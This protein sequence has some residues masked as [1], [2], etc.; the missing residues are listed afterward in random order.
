MRAFIFPIWPE[1][2][3]SKVDVGQSLFIFDRAMCRRIWDS[4]RNHSCWKLFKVHHILRQSTC[5]VWEYITN[6][7]QFFVQV[8]WLGLSRHIFGFI[9]H[10]GVVFD[11]NSLE[12][13]NH[14]LRDQK[15]TWYEIHHGQKPS[16]KENS[17]LFHLIFYTRYFIISIQYVW[18]RTFDTIFI[19]E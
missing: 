8:A 9:K 11:L 16:T 19:F 2:R 14:F 12:E 13:F 1:L 3:I 6:L 5:L 4:I 15:R 17:H 18:W 10:C 7:S